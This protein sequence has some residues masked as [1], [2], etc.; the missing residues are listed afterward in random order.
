MVDPP[1]EGQVGER[2]LLERLCGAPQKVV[3]SLSKASV[4]CVSHALAFVKS[5]LPEAQL[6]TFAQGVA[7]ECTEDRCTEYLQEARPIAEQIVENIL[8][9]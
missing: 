2:P 4:A 8:Q 1:E 5:F 6:E 3:K 9:E 7:A